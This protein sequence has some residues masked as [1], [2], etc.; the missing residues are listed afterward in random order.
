LLIVDD[1]HAVRDSCREVAQEMG[2]KVFMAESVAAAALHLELQPFDVVLLDIKLPAAERLDFLLK[3]KQQQP[4]TE[5]IVST[6]H[7]TVESVLTA[8]KSGA[9]DYLRKPFTRDQFRAVLQRIT[10]DLGSSL[11]N[12]N[13]PEHLTTG[14]GY[15][16]LIG[17][18][19]EMEKLYRI[20]AKVAGS[21]HPVLIVGESGTGKKTVARAIHFSGPFRDKPFVS[22][23]CSSLPPLLL[24]SELFGHAKGAFPGAVAAKEGLLSLAQ[25]GTILLDNIAEMPLETQGKLLQALHEKRIRPAGSVKCIPID[26][27]VIAAS[28]RDLE[29]AM[30]QGS[31]RRDLYSRLNVVSL[32]LP[33]LRERK[34]DIRLLVE[35]FLDRIYRSGGVRR[36]IS[37]D[38]MKQLLAYDWPGNVRELEDCIERAATTSFGPMLNPNDLPPQIQNASIVVSIASQ[39]A[40]AKIISLAELEKQAIISALQQ[41]DGDKLMAAKMLGI[42]KTTLYRKL[43]QYGISDQWT[44]AISASAAKTG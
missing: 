34:A 35:H 13:S 12:G 16:G 22:V 9:Y 17:G 19:P 33:A 43:K 40:R 38:A 11:E 3:I 15:S 23:D 2:F 10:T 25:H 4:A 39:A 5:V 44:M 28:T 8:M 29:S 31:F 7:A 42:G 32:R 20:T 30:Q 36:S 18:S 27:R 37:S 21:R 6:G 41:L 1:E 24:E 14:S 26:V